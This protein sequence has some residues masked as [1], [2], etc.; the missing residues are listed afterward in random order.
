VFAKKGLREMVEGE[1]ILDKEHL[2]GSPKLLSGPI[3][4][5]G[6]HIVSEIE[7]F[8]FHRSV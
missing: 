4:G 7:D 2:G 6:F 1:E 5:I 8:S 3:L